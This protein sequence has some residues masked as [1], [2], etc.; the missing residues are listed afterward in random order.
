VTL[1]DLRPYSLEFWPGWDKH[2]VRFDRT[3]RQRILTKFGHMKQPL[4][5]RGLHS[6]HYHVEEVG[7]YRI[8]YKLDEE[9]RVKIIQFVGDHK[10]YEDW[11]WSISLP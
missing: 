6:S 3:T 5:G 11:Y 7:G 1:F 4:L 2:F 9:R 8:A 10:Q